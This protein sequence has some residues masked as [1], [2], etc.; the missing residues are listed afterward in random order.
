MD[1]AYF[2]FISLMTIGFGD[3]VPGVRYIYHRTDESD[4]EMA[5]AKLVIGTIY[6]LLGMAILGMCLNLM[7]EKIVLQVRTAARRLGL[8]RPARFEDLE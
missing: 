4:V 8:L 6:I 2:C 7:Q 3:F 1:G 5:N